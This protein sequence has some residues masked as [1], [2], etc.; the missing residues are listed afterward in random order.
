MA[1]LLGL[2]SSLRIAFAGTWVYV[3]IDSQS[4]HSTTNYNAGSS[5]ITAGTTNVHATLPYVSMTAQAD[6]ASSMTGPGLTSGTA[7]CFQRSAFLIKWKESYVGEGAPSTVYHHHQ[8]NGSVSVGK[9]VGAMTFPKILGASASAS[10]PGGG[11]SSASVAG[12]NPPDTAS[13]NDTVLHSFSFIP[14]WVYDS[15]DVNGLVTYRTV[16]PDIDSG[17]AAAITQV[18]LLQMGNYGSALAGS[19]VTDNFYF[20]ASATSTW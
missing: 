14:T 19:A 12:S 9:S 6:T 17:T 5:A 11:G 15:T 10:F 7:S 2:A 8:Y 1:L 3:G 4:T 18:W 16:T 20:S 13:D